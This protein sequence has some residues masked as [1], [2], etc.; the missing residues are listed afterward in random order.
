MVKIGRMLLVFTFSFYLGWLG[1]GGL[2]RWHVNKHKGVK[3]QLCCSIW[4]KG[5]PSWRHSRNDAHSPQNLSS[6]VCIMS[7]DIGQIT[8][9]FSVIKQV[10]TI[11]HR[12]C[13]FMIKKKFH[14]AVLAQ[15]LLWICRWDV[16]WGCSRMKAW[17]VVNDRIARWP[18]HKV[19][20]RLL[21]CF[22]ENKT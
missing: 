20:S 6:T 12:F 1:N 9:K 7:T 4:E 14:W 13:G 16:C 2:R 3:N 10:F 8:P 21:S 11:F 17:L 22:P 5:V 19:R 18:T 15:A